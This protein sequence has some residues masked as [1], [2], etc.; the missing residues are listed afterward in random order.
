MRRVTRTIKL[1]FPQL[2]KTKSELFEEITV[3]ATDLANWLLTIPLPERRKLTTSKVQTR[4]MSALSNQV[5]RHTTSDAGKKAKSFK[6]LPPEVNNQNWALH[7]VGTTYSVSFP[8][9]KG[10]KRVPVEVASKHWQPVLEGILNGAVERGSAKI[11]KHRNKWYVYVSVTEEVPEVAT[12]TRIGC[13]RGQNNLAVVASKS[14]FGKFFSGKQ[15]MHRRRYF[16]KR[17]K[18]LQEAKK[19]RAL[20]KWDKKERRW[21][22]AVDHTASRRIVRFAEYKNADVVVEDLEGCRKTMKQSKKQRADSAQSRHSWS[23]YSLEMKL[24]YKLAISGLKL[25][26]R[27]APYTSKSCSTCGTLGIRDR[28]HFNCPH[29][30]YHNADLNAARNIAQ[31]DGFACSLDLKKDM[32]AMVMSDSENGLLGAAPNWMKTQSTG[33]GD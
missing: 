31:W 11:I 13:D 9:I 16:Q 26:K 12:T 14:G 25:I 18:Q 10:T 32:A 19:F 7:K 5:I 30:H 3:E 17:R 8:T 2:N 20:K 27:P 23:F 29:G 22:D 28:H 21:M 33:I 4:L 15:V 24:D 6:R 1:K